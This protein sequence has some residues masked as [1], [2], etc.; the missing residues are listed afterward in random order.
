MITWP[1]APAPRLAP[2]QDRAV[3]VPAA[4]SEAE[5]EGADPERP[6]PCPDRRDE[7]TALLAATG[8]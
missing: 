2:A 4:A 7:A 1:Q 3:A 8:S 5:P 6:A